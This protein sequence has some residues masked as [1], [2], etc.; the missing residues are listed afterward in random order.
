MALIDQR[1][2][3]TV[4]ALPLAAIL[5][6]LGGLSVALTFGRILSLSV[7][8]FTT[9]VIADDAFYYFGVA[10]NVVHGYGSTFDRIHPTNGYH[11]LWLIVLLPIYAAVQ[12]KVTVLYVISVVELVFFALGLVSA[13]AAFRRSLSAPGIA[14]WLPVLVLVVTAPVFIKL[15][16][17]GMEASL[18]FATLLAAAN[19][20]SF[21]LAAPERRNRWTLLGFAF[22][23]SFLSRID[24]AV[25]AANFV[26]FLVLVTVRSGGDLRGLIADRLIPML[27]PYVTIVALYFG[28][29]MLNYRHLLTTSGTAKFG[30][31]LSLETV[32]GA[33]FCLG[34]WGLVM[35]LGSAPGVDAARFA[36][37]FI[38]FPFLYWFLLIS[39][40][41]W[42]ATLFKSWYHVPTIVALLLVA[43]I[44]LT[45]LSRRP[46]FSFLSDRARGSLAPALGAVV[47]LLLVFAGYR[48][49]GWWL[50]NPSYRPFD[51]MATA[52]VWLE[53]TAQPNDII[54]AFDGGRTG[55]FAVQRTIN[56]DGLANSYGYLRV[57]QNRQL[58]SYL[59]KQHV[60]YII[61]FSNPGKDL[62]DDRLVPLDP[63][64]P[65]RS[66][67]KAVYRIE[68][69][70]PHGGPSRW[71][72]VLEFLPNARKS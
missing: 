14:L 40:S 69:K 36:V 37:P 55:Y 17:A 26:L 31:E 48:V 61:N 28:W 54:A 27:A 71:M 45:D 65:W 11:P 10:Y 51:A 66:E 60:R 34:V 9:Q 57:V 22:G 16:F 67:T 20:F 3:A 62:I 19:A 2:L 38:T 21:T 32:I 15:V 12:N 25:L 49:L 39:L 1:R 13:R 46:R 29:N 58:Y 50:T 44:V 56:L 59:V 24:N 5:A 70:D 64:A 53:D 7:T 23:L 6:T 43:A 52:T 47:G 35:R 72:E 41:N 68:L 63:T 4:S 8:T 33:L 30:P 42:R 18:Y